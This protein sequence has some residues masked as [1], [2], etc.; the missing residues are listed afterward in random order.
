MIA[1]SQIRDKISRYLST[2]I[3]LD[4]F[5]DWL[6]QHSWNMQQDSDEEAQN[7]AAAVELRLAE[8][9]SGHLSAFELREELRSL[10]NVFPERI[11]F[12]HIPSEAARFS[13][14]NHSVAATFQF[15][16]NAAQTHKPY[17]PLT[18]PASEFVGT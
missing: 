8:H 15:F 3:S 9:S 5:E 6:V 17:R 13:Q 11:A 18:S 4:E 10:L 1:Q 7:L 2:D 16:M 12:G 14:E